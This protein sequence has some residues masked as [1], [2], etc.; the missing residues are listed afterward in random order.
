M[1]DP[2]I[3]VRVPSL[4]EAR[5]DLAGEVLNSSAQDLRATVRVRFGGRLFRKQL[6]V[7]AGGR[8]S[9]HFNSRTDRRW[10][11]MLK[12]LSLLARNRF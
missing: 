5:V 3:R 10:R 6:R 2:R 11:W 7:P 9:Y 12:P 8:A 1:N 4:R